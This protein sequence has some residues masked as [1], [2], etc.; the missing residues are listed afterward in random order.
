M[1]GIKNAKRLKNRFNISNTQKK[2]N[3]EKCENY[4][5]IAVRPQ[6]YKVLSNVLYNRVAKYAE[7]TVGDY[8]NGF[9]SGRG[10]ADNIF[11]LR[12]I[13]ENPYEYNINLHV[14]FVGL[15]KAFASIKRIKIYEI[16]QQKEMHAKLVRL[17]KTAMEQSEGRTILENYLS[18]KF[19]L[20]K[21]VKAR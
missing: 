4:R 10:A 5:G 12:Q 8:Q 6:I 11:T 17:L 9:R 19:S 14:F 13:V 15:K 18:E 2:G 20:F 21:G 16:L 3:K 7:M 1:G